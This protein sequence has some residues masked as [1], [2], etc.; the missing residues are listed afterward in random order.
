MRPCWL[1]LSAADAG[2]LDFAA[3]PS[4]DGSGGGAEVDDFVRGDNR[5]SVA[6]C[7]G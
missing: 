6:A 2:R 3:F 4:E 7:Q 5:L 1:D